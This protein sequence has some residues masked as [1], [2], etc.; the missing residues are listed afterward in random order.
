MSRKMRDLQLIG[1]YSLSGGS[2]PRR[3]RGEYKTRPYILEGGDCWA[4]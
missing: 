1:F 2:A 4:Q 3:A